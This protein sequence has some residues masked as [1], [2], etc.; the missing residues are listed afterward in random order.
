MDFSESAATAPRSPHA[1]RKGRAEHADATQNAAHA[2]REAVRSV[3]DHEPVAARELPERHIQ[4]RSVC[5]ADV[6][7]AGVA[8]TGRAIVNVLHGASTLLSGRRVGR[9]RPGQPVEL[10]AIEQRAHRANVLREDE[11]SRTAGRS[12]AVHRSDHTHAIPFAHSP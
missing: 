5:S 10:A 1:L 12:V 11:R 8:L 9:R 7:C 4:P 3:G 2:R 6:L